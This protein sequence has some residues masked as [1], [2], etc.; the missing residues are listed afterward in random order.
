MWIR[1]ICRKVHNGLNV[2]LSKW[3]LKLTQN[4][5]ESKKKR[6]NK[7]IL[8][9]SSINLGK[10]SDGDDNSTRAMR[11]KTNPYLFAPYILLLY[12]FHCIRVYLIRSIV[13]AYSALASKFVHS[14]LLVLC[15]CS[16]IFFFGWCC[17]CCCYFFI[18]FHQF[19]KCSHR[20][21]N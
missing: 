2:I 17:C 14:R 1:K 20:Q 16:I 15:V 6:K 12:T 13:F 4:R 7:R 10:Y 11:A 9:S 5:K 3:V 21:F 19:S 8:A 18:H